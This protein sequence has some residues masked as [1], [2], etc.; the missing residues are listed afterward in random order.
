M[1]KNKIEM[2]TDLQSLVK[3]HQDAKDLAD[4]WTKETERRRIIVWQKWKDIFN[5][6]TPIEFAEICELYRDKDKPRVTG[7]HV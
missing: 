4:T 2:L 6:S 5:A 1:I 3:A 7:S